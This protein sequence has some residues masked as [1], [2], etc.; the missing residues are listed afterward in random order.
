M[1]SLTKILSLLVLFSCETMNIAEDSYKS[2]SWTSYMYKNYKINITSEPTGAVIEWNN[3]YIG[4][5]PMVYIVDGRMGNGVS[6]I[7]KATPRV[8]GQYTQV[9]YLRNPLPKN[10]Y[11]NM[12]LVPKK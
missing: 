9:K 10:I 1:K 3:N 12:Y 4:K 8:K 5:T 7:L 11:F 6:V 2:E